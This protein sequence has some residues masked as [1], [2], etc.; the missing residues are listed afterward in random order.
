[1][2]THFEIAPGISLSCIQDHRF[3][4]SA[5]TFQYLRPMC[6]EEAAMN[7]LIPSVL[8]RGC[9]SAPDLRRI[10]QRLDDLYGA[11]VSPISRRAGNCQTTGL[12]LSLMDDRFA[13]EGEALTEQAIAFLKELLF[14]YPTEQGGFLPDFVEGEKTNQI[15]A[16][17]A[18]YNDKQ[19]YCSRQLLKSMCREDPFGVSRMGEPADVEAITPQGLLR[20]YE[21]VRRESPVEVLYVGSAAPERM[22]G[23]VRQ[24]FAGE[25]RSPAPLNADAPLHLSAPE[26]L[27]ENLDITQGK[28]C[29]GFV[30][31]VVNRDKEF[32][33][34]Q[35]FNT[36]FGAGMTSK[37][38]LNVREA[39]SLCY[40]IGSSYYGAKG[41]LTVGAGIDFDKEQLT[42]DEILRQLDACRRGEITQ[43]E[44]TAGKEALL[45]SLRATSDSPGAIEGYY[46]TAH[47]SGLN[48]TPERY[49]EVVEKVSLADVVAAARTVTLHSTY[50]LKGE[51]Q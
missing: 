2:L 22:E 24:L 45:S 3:K 36:V 16:I 7:A 37:L 9:K 5:M 49:M 30:T 1:M 15:Y 11:S 20:H 6:T 34:M 35:V 4:H 48:M 10:T 23:L 40:S 33:A 47:L 28:L 32:P 25:D 13:P 31:P 17:E 42:R 27:Q 8:L 26:D 21:K 19:T 39:M 14:D 41:I 46:A 51:S 50:F 12:Y 38:F 43:E 29:M 18:E 44:L